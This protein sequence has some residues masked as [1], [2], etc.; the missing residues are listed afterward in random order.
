MQK[1]AYELC[2]RDWS[3]DCYSSDRSPCIGLFSAHSEMRFE[4][5]GE[6]PADR[7]DGIQRGH[8]LLK[9][10]ADV[11]ATHFTDLRVGEPQEVPV[12][13]MDRTAYDS[14]SDARRVGK[15]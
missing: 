12:H 8:R 9:D 14:R 2:F 1:T 4:R 13:E 10:H 11:A 7:Q 6:L 15:E 3:S 5:L